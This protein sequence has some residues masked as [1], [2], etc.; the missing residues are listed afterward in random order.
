MV[1]ADLEAMTTGTAKAFLDEY[2]T[3]HRTF[4]HGVVHGAIFSVIFLI[5]PILGYATIFERKS[6]KYLLINLGFW[7]ISCGL[8]GG[9]ISAWGVIVH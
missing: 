2:G 8:M 4:G 5:L 9:V 1:S 7:A 3:N 6:A